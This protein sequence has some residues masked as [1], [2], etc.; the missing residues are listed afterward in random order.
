MAQCE[1]G[2][3]V[4]DNGTA[5]F[6]PFGDGNR[7]W[8][9]LL[10]VALAGIWIAWL[11]RAPGILQG[12]DFVRYYSFNAEWIRRTLLAGELPWWNPHVG[13]GRPVLADLQSGVFYPPHLLFLVADIPTASLLLATLHG[14]I[15]AVGMQRLAVAAGATR[16]AATWAAAA[17]IVSPAYAARLVGGNLHYVAAL[18]Y[19]P[20]LLW[21]TIALLRAPG[22]RT[23]AALAV[24][25]ALQLLCGHPQVFWFSALGA[26]V[27]VLCWLL[28]A[29]AP[30]AWRAIG[31]FVVGLGLA[32][33]LT[34]PVLLPFVELIGESNRA[35][36]SPELSRFGGMSARDWIGLVL[37]PMDRFVPDIE[38]HVLVGVPVLLAALAMIPAQARRDRVVRALAIVAAA[39][40]VLAG[41]GPEWLH[42]TFA[43]A[44]PGFSSFRMP[45][46]TSALVVV[47]LLVLAARAWSMASGG[48][49]L[50]WGG[51]MLT[52][53]TLLAAEP[54]LRRWYV[55][56]AEY[57]AEPV[58]AALVRELQ[59]A[60]PA[61][62]PPRLNITTRL[63]RE[64]SGMVTGHS[65]FNAYT[66]LYLA[67]V[68]AFVHAA[69]GLPEPAALNTFPDVRIF[70][71]DPFFSD[72]MALVG[73][74]DTNAREMRLAPQPDP[75]AYLCYATTEPMSWRQ[76]VEAMAAGHDF[77][78]EALIESDADTLISSPD[79]AGTARVVAFANE[80]VT[81]RTH[82]SA[83]ATLV[84]AEAWYPGW[85]A[86]VDGQPARGFPVNGWMRGVH[87]PAGTAEV[88]WRFRQRWF[89]TGCA[90]ALAA[91]AL[92]GLLL[93]REPNRNS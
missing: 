59:A 4:A 18:S 47:A 82:S 17:W 89:T 65:S 21:L 32:V 68:W 2:D 23:A 35:T 12:L 15:A 41:S 19:L 34:A 16:V 69:A 28:P 49:M 72:A 78:R 81:V 58:V 40:A 33:A 9:L 46:R 55:L 80:T 3:R 43:A 73:G 11:A 79:G 38:S 22:G 66:S 25:G 92:V 10:L 37:P 87:V 93:A 54:A 24:V 6:G 51:V 61:R 63:A 5:K 60:D 70:M 39:A 26:S 57:P 85:E 77:H 88:E 76:A 67:R 36:A 84:L 53:L 83:P 75:R 13:L 71:R 1:H 14:A 48:R 90:V 62:V 20:A 29:Q 7:H 45:A 91:L 86:T 50:R 44:L 31:W 42:R 64:N 8:E 74:F 27:F 52:F 56:P 30:G